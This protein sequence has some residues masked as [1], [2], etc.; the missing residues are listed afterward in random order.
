MSKSIVEAK[1]TGTCDQRDL[2]A[3]KNWFSRTNDAVNEL[4]FR[5]GRLEARRV[6]RDCESAE[7]IAGSGKKE[8]SMDGR[9]YREIERPRGSYDRHCDPV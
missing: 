5:P 9:R 6:R 1:A 3:P 7:S 8:Y 2:K 4:W